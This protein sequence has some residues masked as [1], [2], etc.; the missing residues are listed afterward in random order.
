MRF[1]YHAFDVEPYLNRGAQPSFVL[2]DLSPGMAYCTLADPATGA[3]AVT[4]RNSDAV[5]IPV[6]GISTAAPDTDPDLARLSHG[7]LLTSVGIEVASRFLAGIEARDAIERVIVILA[8]NCHA[9]TGARYRT[10]FGL[11]AEI[12]RS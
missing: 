10:Y 7:S 4:T 1:E 12:R 5:R 9:L 3:H 11:A 8:T 6:F 2:P